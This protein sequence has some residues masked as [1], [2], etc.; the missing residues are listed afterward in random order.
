MKETALTPEHIRLGARM[1][2]FAG[3]NMPIYY[4][5]INDEHLAVRNAVGIFDV[6]HMGEFIVRGPHAL[7]LIQWVTSNDVSRLAPGK[8]QYSCLP[9]AGGGI[10]DDLLVYCLGEQEYMLVVNASNIQKDWDWI[11]SH[12]KQGAEMT[13]ISDTITLLAVQGPRAAVTLQKL[14]DVKLDKVPYYSFVRGAL[15]GVKD[16]IISATGYTGAGGFELYFDRQHALKVWEAVLEAGYPLGIRP[17]GLGA[18]DTLRLEMGYCLYGNDIDETTSPLEAGLGW[19]T[20]FTKDFIGKEVLLKQKQAG[21]TKKLIG[22][23]MQDK[24]IPR[25]GYAVFDPAGNRIGK[26]TSG[27]M[28]PVLKK[29]IGLGYVAVD[30]ARPDTEIH[31]QIRNNYQPARVV[32][33]PFLKTTAP[34]NA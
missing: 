25:P 10:V 7:E 34:A 18:R 1:G 17:A 30:F 4:T 24:A 15:A 2:E 12:N 20:K 26:V 28:S 16:V 6:S 5:G 8:A 27:T 9:N 29:P 11:T 31:I 14:T 13:D 32:Q 19:I 21:L 33:L 22:F 23:E 3:Y